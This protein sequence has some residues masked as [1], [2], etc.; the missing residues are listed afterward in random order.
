[1]S[2]RGTVFL[3]LRKPG[4]TG[5]HGARFCQKNKRFIGFGQNLGKELEKEIFTKEKDQIIIGFN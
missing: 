4:S 3:C 1:L 5:K 2:S